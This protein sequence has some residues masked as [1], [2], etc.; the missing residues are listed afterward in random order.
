MSKTNLD[1]NVNETTSRLLLF[2][3]HE[4]SCA[5]ECLHKC[6]VLLQRHCTFPCSFPIYWI[7]TVIMGK[8]NLVLEVAN[9]RFL[10]QQSKFRKFISKLSSKC[11]LLPAP[12][13]SNSPCGF[14]LNKS[15]FST[16]KIILIPEPG[17]PMKC[18]T[19]SHKPLWHKGIS[20]LRD[21]GTQLW[22]TV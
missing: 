13:N 11:F 6:K 4:G 10:G 22:V 21:T 17:I 3:I 19:F 18:H 9:D 1:R 8:C 5:D 15:Q 16:I 20:L 12:Q 7:G 14:M 2:C